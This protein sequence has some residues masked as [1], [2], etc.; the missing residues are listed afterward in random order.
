M[1][2]PFIAEIRMFGFN[3]APRNWALCQGQL[4]AISQNTALFSI[5]GTQYG[6]NGTSNFALPDFR[7]RIPVG[8]GN[9]P[10][11]SPYV[12]GEVSGVENVS[13]TIST[14]P[15]HHHTAGCQTATGNS[16]TGQSG[17]PAPDA[18]GNNVYSSP[19]NSVMNPLALAQTGGSSAHNNLQPYLTVN[20]CIA[21][22]GVFP[23]R[24]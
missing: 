2:T 16:Y 7:S 6:G 18:G 20:Y 8:S 11:L 3:F 23:S 1:S 21:L 5:L 17:V 9:G 12:N 15:A 14:L 4:L 13:L 10:G 24:S 22:L 19:P